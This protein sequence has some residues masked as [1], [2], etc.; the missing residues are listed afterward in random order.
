MVLAD[1]GTYLSACLCI[2]RAYLLAGMPGRL[3]PL[4]GFNDW[5]N[6]VRSALVWLGCEDPAASLNI[7]YTEDEKKQALRRFVEAWL[8]AVGLDVPLTVRKLL[9]KE[10]ELD[11]TNSTCRYPELHDAIDVICPSRDPK[12]LGNWL[13]DAKRKV[14]ENVEFGGNDVAVQIDQAGLD[15]RERV[16]RWRLTKVKG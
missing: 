3:P 16:V 6:R 1:R 13:R 5:S 7:A 2:P 8:D 11:P 10:E 14:V 12:D 4:A 9:A 15:S